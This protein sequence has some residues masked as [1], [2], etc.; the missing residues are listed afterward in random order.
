MQVRMDGSDGSAT[1][2]RMGV[3][4]STG[5]FLRTTTK[6]DGSLLLEGAL[7]GYLEVLQKL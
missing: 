6:S 7:Q 5:A 4:Q 1:D 2:L 3:P